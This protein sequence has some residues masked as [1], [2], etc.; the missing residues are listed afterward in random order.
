MYISRTGVVLLA[1]LVAMT[2]SGCGVYRGIRAKYEINEG[3]RAYKANQFRQAQGHFQRA[4]ELDPEQKNALMFIAHAIRA[5]YRQG[6]DTEEN[7]TVARNAIA[8]YQRVLEQEPNNEDAYNA[9][10]FLY[11]A[12]N[13]EQAQREW[14]MRRAQLEGVPSERR[15]EAYVVLASKQWNCSFTITEQ[16]ENKQTVM[17]EGQALIQYRMPG[18]RNKFTEA[19]R[20]A[21]EGMRL[22]EEAIR[23]NPESENAWGYRV[24]LLR[25]MAKLA[26][27]ENNAEA[28]QRYTREADE[29][30]ERTN[31]LNQQQRQRREA[32]A[33]QSPPAAG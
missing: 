4:H 1:L 30:Q 2:T 16:Q 5:Q 17:R 25:E 19:Q 20:C 14:I 11:G 13:D 29:A 32:Q 21:T 18:D 26:E 10:A 31:Q 12:I 28:R 22:I 7:K 9:V 6:V 24:S 23:L 3:A 8:A 33:A 27:M 15:A